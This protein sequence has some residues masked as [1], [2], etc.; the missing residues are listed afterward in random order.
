MQIQINIIIFDCVG[1]QSCNSFRGKFLNVS[2][3]QQNY[4]EN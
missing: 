2:Q 4:T 1:Q 3:Q